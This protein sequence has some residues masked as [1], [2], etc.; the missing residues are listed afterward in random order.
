MT[1][2]AG[3]G[4]IEPNAA[5]ALETQGHV[6]VD[7]IGADRAASLR[8]AVLDLVSDTDGTTFTD[9]QLDPAQRRQ[10]HQGIVASLGPALARVVPHHRVVGA[11]AIVKA[12]VDTT[13]LGWHLDPSITDEGRWRSLSAWVPLQDVG[14]ADGSIELLAGGH[15]GAPPARG[16]LGRLTETHPPHDVALAGCRDAGG[17]PTGPLTLAAGTA[18]IYDHRLPH[19]SGPNRGASARVAVNVGLL[20]VEAPL[21]LHIWDSAGNLDVYPVE[22]EAFITADLASDPA[23]WAASVS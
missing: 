17:T 12:P 11:S 2:Q 4:D 10:L 18:V 16:G 21:L 9:H 19:R 5:R 7:L 15:R 13:D 14:P 22:D 6:I 3:E 20:P 1:D 8:A 23:T